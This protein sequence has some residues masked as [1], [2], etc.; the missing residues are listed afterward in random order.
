MTSRTPGPVEA[1]ASPAPEAAPPQLAGKPAP[2]PFLDADMGRETKGLIGFTDALRLLAA[3]P[4]ACQRV[5]ARSPDRGAH[6][7]CLGPL[8]ALIV[9]VRL[10]S[11]PVFAQLPGTN[12]WRQI[13]DRDAILAMPDGKPVG[14]AKLPGSENVTA[15]LA[16]PSAFFVGGRLDE[17]EREH[18][19]SL[20]RRPETPGPTPSEVA[21]EQHRAQ[22]AAEEAEREARRQARQRAD[23]ARAE[24]RLTSMTTNLAN[25]LEEAPTEETLLD[26]LDRCAREQAEKLNQ[27]SPP[28]LPDASEVT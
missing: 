11:V 14:L 9:L 18:Q 24:A 19:E 1:A 5:F 16:F 21:L 25:A 23:E 27:R 7:P 3:K 26:Y 4:S 28:H 2:M 20:D 13:D 12:S 10:G 6:L 17:L 8:G 22:L 15:P